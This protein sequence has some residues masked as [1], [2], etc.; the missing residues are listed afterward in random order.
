MPT[1]CPI[2]ALALHISG[3]VALLITC[4]CFLAVS[5]TC[6]FNFLA[7]FRV[8]IQT[9]ADPRSVLIPF[10][11]IHSYNN[12][13]SA[14]S[15]IL[16]S[17]Q[18]DFLVFVCRNSFAGSQNSKK[19]RRVFRR[20]SHGKLDWPFATICPRLILFSSCQNDYTQIL[21]CLK[22]HPAL[23]IFISQSCPSAA[24]ILESPKISFTNRK[25]VVPSILKLSDTDFCVLV[26]RKSYESSQ[27]SKK[28]KWLIRC[29]IAGTLD[30]PFPMIHPRLI[31]SN[32]CQEHHP[33]IF[34]SK[35][36]LQYH[37]VLKIVHHAIQSIH[38]SLFR[39]PICDPFT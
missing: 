12:R 8:E 36:S 38:P 29:H 11:G 2:F 30:L 18:T 4:V 19:S 34:I 14:I 39:L 23:Y 17:S 25:S 35:K 3:P 6:P 24:L 1:I 26:C 31:R 21:M 20:P 9:A 15:S 32:S 10:L 7:E 37:H 13:R 22:L 5:W 33:R 16:N 28:S 27:K